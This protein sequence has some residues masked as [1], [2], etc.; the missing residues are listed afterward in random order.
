MEQ[1]STYSSH[2][3]LSFFYN[4]HDGFAQSQNYQQL[5]PYIYLG[6]QP[7]S[8]IHR[9]TTQGYRCNGVDYTFA[10]CDGN[11]NSYFV[12]YF[13]KQ[14]K[15][16]I[17][18]YTHCCDTTLMHEWVTHANTVPT[19]KYLP[20]GFY[21]FFEMHMGGCGGYVIPNLLKGVQGAALGLRFGKDISVV[22]LIRF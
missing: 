12:F 17:G 14:R 16:P 3:N 20:A 10:N 15:I 19:S 1:L 8:M 5:S 18:Y 11:P 4:K 2:Y 22:I 6:F 21:F 13:N 9:G 7:V